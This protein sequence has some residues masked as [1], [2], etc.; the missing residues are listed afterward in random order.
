LKHGSGGK[1]HSALSPEWSN[2]LSN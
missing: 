1:A 2:P